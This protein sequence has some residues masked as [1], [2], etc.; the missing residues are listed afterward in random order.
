MACFLRY[1]GFSILGHAG[2]WPSGKA[3]DFGSGDRRFESYRP[4]H[5]RFLGG[6]SFLLL[7]LLPV[8]LGC[9]PEGESPTASGSGAALTQDSPAAAE[10]APPN[11]PCPARVVSGAIGPRQSFYEALLARDGIQPLLVDSLLV[12]AKPL[13]DL[14]RVQPGDSFSVALGNAGELLQFRYRHGP[15]ETL[16]V[17]PD[18]SGVFWPR[19]ERAPVERVLRVAHGEI[20][21]NLWN[22]A[23]AAGLD[24]EVTMNLTDIF[25]WQ[26]DFVTETRAGDRFDVLW[27][28]L[29]V[30]GE[31]VDVGPV[32][33]ARYRNR[34]G[35]HVAM[36][37]QLADGRSDYFG[38]DGRSLRLQFLRSPLNYRRISSYFSRG[39]MHPI[40]K[41]VMPHLGVDFA[42]R[43]GTPVVASGDGKVVFAGRKGPNGNMIQLKH[44]SVYQTYYL[45]LARFAR[46]VRRGATVHQGQVIGYVGST[47][48]STGPHLDYRMKR[49]GT[50][51]NPL[52]EKFSEVDGIGDEELPAFQAAWRERM[53]VFDSL[54]ARL[55]VGGGDAG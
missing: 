52:T 40:L 48:R 31:S 54:A 36:R 2:A 33:A 30:K 13:R 17:A 1:K 11:A 38:P 18:S 29:R 8:F 32:L 28:D 10:P 5:P 9:T 34:N 21:D 12:V 6:I 4:S 26:V 16:V 22:A 49:Y 14:A 15:I 45:H 44:G 39:R 7:L 19:L 20:S 53:A 3:P 55:S 23:L 42:A 35:E 27:E 50:F 51:V 41:K 37:Y 25:A 46:G 47:G 43:A 24:P